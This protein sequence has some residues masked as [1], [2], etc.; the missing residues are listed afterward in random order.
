MDFKDRTIDIEDIES[1]Y[2][3]RIETVSPYVLMIAPVFVLM[4]RNAKL[5]CVKAPLDFF[6][7]EELDALRKHEVVYLP[8]AVKDVSRFQTAAR[9]QRAY[10]SI[11]ESGLQRAPFE[12]SNEVL[13]TVFPLWGREVRVEPL[14][15]AIFTDEFCGGLKPD[16]LLVGRDSA[17][18][19]HE[20]GILLSGT[21]VFVLTQLG[22]CDLSKLKKLRQEVYSR[23]IQGEKW[24]SV[25]SDWE[26][27]AR[28]LNALIKSE[29]SLSPLTL[30]N[31]NADWSRKLLGRLKR[32]AE[33]PTAQKY[34]S[35]S[36]ERFLEAS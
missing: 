5:V 12:I 27:L 29:C 8:V 10:F 34:N 6:V 19:L 16:E 22:W 33:S 7:P 11:T 28:D 23:T 17:V 1:L 15:A 9:L 30:K 35:L 21:L 24:N 14:F 36:V 25:S 26:A 32:V 18:L 31:I 2:Q 20:H 3:C 4:K 13:K